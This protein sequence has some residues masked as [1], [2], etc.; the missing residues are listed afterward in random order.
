MAQYK[1]SSKKEEPEEL[2]LSITI[3]NQEKDISTMHK[4]VKERIKTLSCLK[5]QLAAQ[6][7]IEERQQ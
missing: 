6:E 5:T 4:E 3:G 2:K 7:E 1:F